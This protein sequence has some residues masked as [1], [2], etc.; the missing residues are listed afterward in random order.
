[1]KN[2]K[3]S[4]LVPVYGTEYYIERCVRS[5]F[6]QTYSNIEYI[7]VNDCTPDNAIG[8]L[9]RVL[10][11]YPDRKKG[12][13]V[14]NH[15]NNCGIA[16]TRNSALDNA[17][18][19]FVVWVDSDDSVSEK[20][21]EL[22]VNKQ[23]EKDADVVIG[24]LEYV[25]GHSVEHRD[26][27]KAST[28]QEHLYHLLKRKTNS[29]LWAKLW[30]RSI[31]VENQIRFPDGN[32]MEEDGYVSAQFL[33]YAKS[34][35]YVDDV[36]YYYDCTREGTAAFF[37]TTKNQQA[38]NVMEMMKEFFKEKEG[39]H[40]AF[41]AWQQWLAVGTLINCA[42]D[43]NVKDYYYN[44]RNTYLSEIPHSLWNEVEPLKRFTL[45]LKSYRMNMVYF[46][47]MS[48]MKHVV[49]KKQDYA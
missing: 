28:P 40:E 30:R 32:N 43:G 45:Y 11:E 35:D 21:V 27:L 41:L 6:A 10:E 37:N 3:V 12:V 20:L 2:F 13:K 26:F 25:Y 49:L 38:W 22:L 5:L 8:V 36:V 39:F 14:V 4:I 1:M 17:T 18:G 29:G 16:T 24:N 19:D 34:I 7:F 33:Y 15:K 47:F 31:Y 42:K 46:R 44:I 9:Y 23:G 48:W